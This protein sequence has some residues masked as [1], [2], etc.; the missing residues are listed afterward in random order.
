MPSPKPSQSGLSPHVPKLNVGQCIQQ[1]NSTDRRYSRCAAVFSI[2][3]Y[4]CIALAACIAIAK[5]HLCPS[6]LWVTYNRNAN[7][8]AGCCSCL[9]L[10]IQWSFN[11][12]WIFRSR[13]A[14]CLKLIVYRLQT[15]HYCSTHTF[16]GI[17]RPA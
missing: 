1:P 8:A 6:E 15:Q 10:L 4:S 12:S 3:D 11:S 9:A 13:D 7:G 14:N 16:S 2:R 17:V 5:L